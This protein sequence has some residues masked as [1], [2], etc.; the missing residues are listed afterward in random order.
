MAEQVGHS[1]DYFGDYRDFWW[2]HDFLALMASR[3]SWSTRR[4][5]LDVGYGMGHWT[6]TLIPHLS[7]GTHI[8]AV[9]RDPKWSVQRE[10]WPTYLSHSQVSVHIQY[11]DATALPFPD[12]SFDFVTCQTVLIHIAEPE[13]A[14]REMCRVLAP[15]GLLLCVEPDNFGTFASQN[16]LVD[17]ASLAEEANRFAFVLAQHRG[18]IALGLGN[19]SLGGRLPRLLS[20]ASLTNIHVYLSDKAIPLYPPYQ[21]DEQRAMI[22]DQQA[23]F[24]SSL[25]F[26]RETV[27]ERYRA[28]GGDPAIFAEHWEREVR[29]RAQLEEALAA[30]TYDEGG[31]VLMYLVSGIKI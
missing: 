10:N 15:G 28:G 6:R 31:G 9:D 25:D 27:E 30:Q 23:W 24:A 17:T 20:E 4:Q 18:T 11:G 26:S 3:L 19:H 22:A 29:K 16:A 12:N 21:S 7:A 8:T 13:K 14:I 1:E 5:V 2:N